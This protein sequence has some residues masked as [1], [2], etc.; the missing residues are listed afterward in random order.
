MTPSTRCS[1]SE[2]NG[3]VVAGDHQIG[4]EGDMAFDG[5]R[6]CFAVSG[7]HTGFTG[8]DALTL[9]NKKRWPIKEP[10][11]C[12]CSS[13]AAFASRSFCCACAGTANTASTIAI[14]PSGFQRMRTAFVTLKSFEVMRMIRGGH[15]VLT[16]LGATGEIRLVNQLF[17]LAA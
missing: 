1:F 12:P 10:I 5:R 11:C 2:P 8:S 16:Q 7:R 9:A 4:F 15:C 3:Q 6:G 13:A 17:R 14:G